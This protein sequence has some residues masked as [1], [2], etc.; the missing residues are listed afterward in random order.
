MGRSEG[1]RGAYEWM[2]DL[3]AEGWAWEFL[4]RN[5]S[6]RRHYLACR[7]AD[8]V[9]ASRAAHR[10]GLLQFADPDEDA[11]TAVVFWNPAKNQSVLP[12]VTAGDGRNGLADVQCKISILELAWSAQRHVLYSCCGRFLQLA[13]S[14]EGDLNHVR[15]MMNTLPERSGDPKLV[16]LRRLADLT[17]HKRHRPELYSRQKRGPRLSHIAEVLDIAAMNPA[18]RSIARVVFG[19][20]RATDEWDNL[21]DHVRRALSAGRKLTHGG[22]LEFLS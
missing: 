2:L 3:S 13:I 9:A 18:H 11:R 12:L 16:A 15:Y 19:N 21:R 7:E 1:D 10:W 17:Q 8:Q 20:D 5:P 6:Y 4:R 22:Y 14:G